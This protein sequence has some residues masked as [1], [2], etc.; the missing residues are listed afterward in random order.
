MRRFNSFV[1]HQQKNLFNQF[2]NKRCYSVNE[3]T[4]T[5]AVVGA[6]QMGTGIAIVAAMNAKMRVKLMDVNKEQV[7][8]SMKFA[9][10]SA[11][12]VLT[13]QIIF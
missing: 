5:F 8:K 10:M 1:Q 6:G 13:Q 9:G 11:A 7:D 2:M 3:P 12:N 4:Q